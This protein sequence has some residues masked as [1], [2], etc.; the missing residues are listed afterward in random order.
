MTPMD[1]HPL[2]KVFRGEMDTHPYVVYHIG[3][4]LAVTNDLGLVVATIIRKSRECEEFEKVAEA[5]EHMQV[6]RR[7]KD[8]IVYFPDVAW[9]DVNGRNK[10]Q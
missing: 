9:V 2:Y 6:E 4:Y 10:T 3:T 5:V 8:T 1:K 7:G